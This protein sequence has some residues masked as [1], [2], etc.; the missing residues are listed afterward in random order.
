MARRNANSRLR[1][2]L[3]PRG[4]GVIAAAAALCAY[5]ASPPGS[6]ARALFV[7]N[8][9][10][11]APIGLYRV[12]RGRALARGDLVL[13]VPAPQLAAFADARSY[14]PRGVPL[15]KRVAAVAGDAVCVRGNTVF[16][17]GRVAAVRL[18]AD[19]EGRALPSWTGCGTLRVNEVFLL[20][21]NARASFDGRYF[22]PTSA[23]QVVGLLDPLWTR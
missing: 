13:A 16:I 3:A 10:A 9:S 18:A 5:A 1:N 4:L 11:S 6:P 8:A 2:T 22:G 7:W 17:D 20:M 21:T 23:S 19:R 12:S 14:L 15:V